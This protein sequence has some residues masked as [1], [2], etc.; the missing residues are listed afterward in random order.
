VYEQSCVQ[1]MIVGRG[2]EVVIGRDKNVWKTIPSS[3]RLAKYR[4][5]CVT[6]IRPSCTSVSLR[7]ATAMGCALSIVVYRGIRLCTS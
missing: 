5:V 2:K 3:G 4:R 1:G 6:L 7:D